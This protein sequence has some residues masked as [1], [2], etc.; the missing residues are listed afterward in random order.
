MALKYRTPRITCWSMTMIALINLPLL[1]LSA[2][3]FFGQDARDGSISIGAAALNR[4]FLSHLP[5]QHLVVQTKYNKISWTDK[6][7]AYR[8]RFKSLLF[9]PSLH[10]I[11]SIIV[12]A[13][14]LILREERGRIRMPIKKNE[15][16][17][18][19]RY[20]YN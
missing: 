1:C 5:A 9:H 7:D 8:F 18:F 6:F 17:R 4:L 2:T 12:F 15:K 19:A 13:L 11:Q 20:C 10:Y 16:K 3:L 14:V